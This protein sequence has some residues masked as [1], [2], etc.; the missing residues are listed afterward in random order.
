MRLK[1]DRCFLLCFNNEFEPYAFSQCA[2]AHVRW[3][4][5]KL[6]MKKRTTRK[7]LIKTQWLRAPLPLPVLE[8]LT[9]IIVR[10]GST[11]RWDWSDTCWFTKVLIYFLKKQHIF[12]AQFNRSIDINWAFSIEQYPIYNIVKIC[13]NKLLNLIKMFKALDAVIV[14]KGWRPETISKDITPI[15]TRESQW[16][17]RMSCPLHSHRWNALSASTRHRIIPISSFTQE[18]TQVSIVYW[19]R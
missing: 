9:A 19:Y 13:E 1:S 8:I 14:A 5:Q 4:F 10:D 6:I 18:S 17:L 15:S 12:A 3:L 16:K 2:S 11:V 7:I